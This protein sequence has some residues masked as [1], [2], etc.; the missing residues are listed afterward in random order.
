MNDGVPLVSVVVATRNEA[1][2]IGACLRSVNGQT[3]PRIEVLVADNFSTDGTG[4]AALGATPRATVIPCGPERCGQRNTAAGM[5]RGD[6]ILFIDADMV[7]APEVVAECVAA[8][9]ELVVIPEES[10]GEGFWGRVR[11]Y[12]RGF[13]DRNSAVAAARFISRRL[14]WAVGGYDESLYAAGEDWDLHSRARERCRPV[15]IEA[16][17]THVE[18]RV[19]LRSYLAKKAYYAT[20]LGKY[21]NKWGRSAGG[22]LGPGRLL[23]YLRKPRRIVGH[24]L[25]FAAMCVMLG[26]AYVTYKKELVRDRLR[27]VFSGTSRIHAGGR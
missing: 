13:Y 6:Y 18:G 11:A 17:I 15:W 8:G 14:F 22:R 4:E 26:A 7:L 10:S 1:G 25:L 27:L 3:H 5:A 19:T 21:Q 24:P 2:R 23:C 16:G 12:E 20:H 9:S